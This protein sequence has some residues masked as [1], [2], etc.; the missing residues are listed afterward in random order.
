MLFFYCDQ[1][2]YTPYRS[3]GSARQIFRYNFKALPLIFLHEINGNFPAAF[4]EIL[5]HQVADILFSDTLII[6]L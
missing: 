3:T 6:F 1:V 2:Y 4:E 5:I